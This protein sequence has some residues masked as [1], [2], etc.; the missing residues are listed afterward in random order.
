[1]AATGVRTYRAATAESFVDA[2]SDVDV[3]LLFELEEPFTDWG[4]SHELAAASFVGRV[5]LWWHGRRLRVD[6]VP[7]QGSHHPVYIVIGGWHRLLPLG[8]I[9]SALVI[10]SCA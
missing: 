10:R 7:A 6:P 4:V 5:I 1:M 8:S 9:R 2:D 3:R